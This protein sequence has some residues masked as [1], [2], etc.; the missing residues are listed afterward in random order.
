MPEPT[1]SMERPAEGAYLFNTEEK[2]KQLIQLDWKWYNERK[3][4]IDARV[5]RIF[6]A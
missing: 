5:N 2:V 4:E 6:K 3:D 1:V